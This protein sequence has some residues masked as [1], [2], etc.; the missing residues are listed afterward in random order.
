M[1]R[2]SV[3]TIENMS[4]SDAFQFVSLCK[5]EVI[6]PELF[7]WSNEHSPNQGSHYSY[8]SP[9]IVVDELELKYSGSLEL[10]V[11]IV[12]KARSGFLIHIFDVQN[13]EKIIANETN[14]AQYSSHLLTL[15]KNAYEKK[16]YHTFDDIAV[17]FF[18]FVI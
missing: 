6:V 7:A 4:A 18:S 14:E 15:M 17:C 9:T 3:E 10:L 5:C 8:L 1:F 2:V 16:D 13:A 12:S 11:R